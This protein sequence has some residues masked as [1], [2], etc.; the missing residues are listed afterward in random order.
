M[1]KLYET[2]KSVD[3]EGKAIIEEAE[4]KSAAMVQ[5]TKDEVGGII[6]ESKRKAADAEESL[7][8]SYLERLDELHGLKGKDFEEQLESLKEIV[9]SNWDEAVKNV[10]DLIEKQL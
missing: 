8:E 2:L 9:Q 7:Q 10:L 3:D 6:E 1:E 4:R 5:A